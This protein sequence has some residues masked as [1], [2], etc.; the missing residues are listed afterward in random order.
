MQ[1]RLVLDIHARIAEAPVWDAQRQ[2]LLWTDHEQGFIYQ[3]R[4]QGSDQWVLGPVHSLGDPLAAALPCQDG[5]LI[6]AGGRAL[7]Y[8]N[9]DGTVSPV[10]QLPARTTSIFN[11]A[12][13]DR[14]GRL[15]VGTR[16]MDFQPGGAALYRLDGDRTLTTVLEDVT[17]SNGMDWSPDGRTFYYIDSPTLAIDAFDFDS[18]VGTLSRRRRLVTLEY[19]AGAPDGMTVDREGGLW[20]AIAGAGEVRRYAA[21]GSLLARVSISAPAVTSCCFGGANYDHLFITCLGRRLPEVALALGLTAE[22]MERAATA[23]GAGGLFVCRP[24]VRGLPA[25]VFPN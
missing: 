13:V 22:V 25:T 1:A 23:P 3:A 9:P 4:A 15:W 12:K 14:Q 7:H 24:G 8:L 2:R 19:G 6:V 21:D 17:I 11:E 5:R 16:T 10:A 20:V 18:A